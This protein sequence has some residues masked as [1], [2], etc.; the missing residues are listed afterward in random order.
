MKKKAGMKTWH[1]GA[2]IRSVSLL[3]TSV[4]LTQKRKEVIVFRVILEKK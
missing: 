2:K 1:A 4:K 3:M